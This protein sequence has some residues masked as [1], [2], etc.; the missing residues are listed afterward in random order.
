VNNAEELVRRCIADGRFKFL[1]QSCVVRGF[2]MGPSLQAELDQLIEFELDVAIRD[3]EGS[4][5]DTFDE[6]QPEYEQACV[7]ENSAKLDLI[8]AGET[9]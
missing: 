6:V 5:V 3:L 8:L 1:E 7:D 9:E 2:V 4:D